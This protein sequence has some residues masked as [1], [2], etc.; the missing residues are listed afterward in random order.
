MSNLRIIDIRLAKISFKLNEGTLDKKEEA[1]YRFKVR[2]QAEQNTLTGQVKVRLRVTSATNDQEPNFPFFFDTVLIGTFKAA[3]GTSSEL[4][5]QF[6]KINCPAMMFPYV[7]E[8]IADLTRRAGFP[9]LHL[10]PINFVK[11]AGKLSKQADGK[12]KSIAGGKPLNEKTSNKVASKA[13]KLSADNKTLK[14]IKPVDT[15]QSSA[16]IGKKPSKK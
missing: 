16:V 8:T 7:R 10:P 14:S 1:A 6:A 3:E 9:P 13:T 11:Q 2:M 5:E 4:M 12:K 15:P